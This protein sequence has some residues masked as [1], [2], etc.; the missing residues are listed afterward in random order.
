[1]LR[2]NCAVGIQRRHRGFFPGGFNPVAYILWSSCQWKLVGSTR[3]S[4][5]LNVVDSIVVASAIA[6]P[7]QESAVHFATRRR[8]AYRSHGH[9]CSGGGRLSTDSLP[10]RDF[11]LRSDSCLQ[12]YE[13]QPFFR[14]TDCGASLSRLRS[15][16]SVRS[17][18]FSS[19]NRFASCA[20]L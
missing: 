17:R 11:L 18:V 4:H 13:L 8:S 5:H 3:H 9:F 7:A 15:A 20:W 1:M 12:R 19:R 2:D 6:R 16:T 10:V 14:I